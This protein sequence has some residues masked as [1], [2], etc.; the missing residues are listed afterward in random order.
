MDYAI[1]FYGLLF[2]VAFL[3]ASVGHGGASGYLALMALFNFTPDVMRPTAL[4]LNLFVSLMSFVQYYRGGYFRW[5][6]FLPLA[7]ASVPAAYIGG[8]MNLPG[9]A[10]KIILG[11][12]LIVTVAWLLWRLKAPQHSWPANTEGAV[13][14]QRWILAGLIGAG[15]GLLSGLIGI[16]G[17]VLLSPLLLILGWANIKQTAAVSALFIFVNSASGLA[18]QLQ[19]GLHFDGQM[20]WFVVVAFIGGS[21][22]AYLGAKTFKQPVL[23]W[24]LSAVLLV[25][26]L[27]LILV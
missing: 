6:L 10:Y 1:A 19:K 9:N 24:L 22:G 26:A 7:V 8:L 16:G 15:I 21:I 18:G 14:A 27:K 20:A 25:A 4:V 17:G 3:Y 5:S 13:P 2:I 11:V 23:Q 12:L